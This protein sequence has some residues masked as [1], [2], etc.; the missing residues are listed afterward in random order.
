MHENNSTQMRVRDLEPVIEVQ[1]LFVMLVAQRASASCLLCD[2]TSYPLLVND[3]L[4]VGKGSP[5]LGV[6][7]RR[8]DCLANDNVGAKARC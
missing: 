6:E 7:D 3:A 2:Y 5:T 8:P 1:F 4:L